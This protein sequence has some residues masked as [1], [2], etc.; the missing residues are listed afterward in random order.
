[1][2]DLQYF[3]VLRVRMCECEVTM[4]TAVTS[5]GRAARVYIC[6]TLD[7]KVA[8]S[9]LLGEN[10]LAAGSTRPGYQVNIDQP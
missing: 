3:V 6:P 8:L 1:M 4:Y 9:R 2:D 10:E 7:F 5:F